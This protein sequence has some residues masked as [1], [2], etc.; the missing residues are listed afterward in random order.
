MTNQTFD[1]EILYYAKEHR[2]D[3]SGDALVTFALEQF[4]NAA[5]EIAPLDASDLEGITISRDLA[6]LATGEYLR[7]DDPEPMATH[8]QYIQA[9]ISRNESLLTGH[10]DESIA[11]VALVGNMS[12]QIRPLWV[13]QVDAGA[14]N[15]ELLPTGIDTWYVGMTIPVRNIVTGTGER[16][17]RYFGNHGNH[18]TQL[19]SIVIR[20]FGFTVSSNG[21]VLKDNFWPTL[22]IGWKNIQSVSLGTASKEDRKRFYKAKKQANYSW[23]HGLR[24]D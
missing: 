21:I 17:T 23:H 9:E 5:S 10:I 4:I 22:K 20:P 8:A 3:E 24:N 13:G 18:L 14:P 11:S 6:K 16:D 7:G 12:P 1:A 19:G 2:P 15:Y